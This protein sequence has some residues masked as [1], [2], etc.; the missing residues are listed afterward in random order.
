MD[1][2]AALVA[3]LRLETE[4]G[5]GAGVEAGDPDRLAG[6]LAIAIA[7]VLDPAHRLVDLG[8]ELALPVPGP[9]F[10][11]DKG[12]TH[13]KEDRHGRQTDAAA[14]VSRNYMKS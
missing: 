14:P 2:L 3:L 13:E 5:D 6:V 9:Q 12:D 8:N 11:R 10:Q 4:R 7:S 1:A